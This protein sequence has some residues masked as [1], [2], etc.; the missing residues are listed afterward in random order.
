VELA[1]GQQPGLL[2]SEVWPA[3]FTEAAVNGLK[4]HGHPF[5]PL[6]KLVKADGLRPS[7]TDPFYV[8]IQG[9]SR[10]VLRARFGA[11][12][13]GAT[14]LVERLAARSHQDAV[15]EEDFLEVQM[16]LY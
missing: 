10:E 15:S 16:T 9:K 7:P 6:L 13:E 4:R 8:S 14:R 5:A 3:A 2:E 12:Q 1:M 11:L